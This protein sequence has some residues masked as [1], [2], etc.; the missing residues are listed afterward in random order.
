MKGKQP[1]GRHCLTSMDQSS[2]SL[3]ARYSQ[4]AFKHPVLSH[5]RDKIQIRALSPKQPSSRERRHPHH[6]VRSQGF[7]RCSGVRPPAICS[8]VVSL[9]LYNVVGQNRRVEQIRL[10]ITVAKLR[11]NLLTL[12]DSSTLIISMSDTRH[13]TPALPFSALPPLPFPFCPLPTRWEKHNRVHASILSH[14]ISSQHNP[15]DSPHP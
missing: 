4:T 3:I 8:T 12:T 9:D 13:A 1:I 11:A 15:H 2:G 14:S 5:H 6:R 7:E 10:S